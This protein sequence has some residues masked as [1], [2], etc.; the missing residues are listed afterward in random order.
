MK[1]VLFATTALVAT[2]GVAAAEV[3]VGGFGYFGVAHDSAAADETFVTHA[4]RLTFSASVE[5][6]SGVTFGAS[7]RIT[8]SDNNDNGQLGDGT[9]DGRLTPTPLSS[10]AP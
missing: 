1:K 6:D 4:T 3:S 9:T 5:T 2:A 8:I 10:P 7:S